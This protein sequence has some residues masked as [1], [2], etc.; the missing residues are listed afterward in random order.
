M[1]TTPSVVSRNNTLSVTGDAVGLRG[2]IG[3]YNCLIE[4]VALALRVS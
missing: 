4:F 1:V 2:P 3:S